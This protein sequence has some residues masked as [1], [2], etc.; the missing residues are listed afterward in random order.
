MHLQ[1]GE[2]ASLKRI[3]ESLLAQL[4]GLRLSLLGRGSRQLKKITACVG[5]IWYSHSGDSPP[6][7]LRMGT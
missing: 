3:L 2:M 5:P 4:F 7:A 1:P 6:N